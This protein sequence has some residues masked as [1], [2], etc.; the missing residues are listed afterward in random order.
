MSLLAFACDPPS[1]DTVVIEPSAQS[2][3]GLR[4]DTPAPIC[5]ILHGLAGR[6][7]GVE[8]E[9]T[10]TRGPAAAWIVSAPSLESDYRCTAAPGE[11]RDLTHRSADSLRG[12]GAPRDGAEVACL[13]ALDPLLEDL[14]ARLA[15]LPMSGRGTLVLSLHAPDD[16]AA[17]T[18]AA[19]SLAESLARFVHTEQVYVASDEPRLLVE[20]RD[21]LHERQVYNVRTALRIEDRAGTLGT[22]ALDEAYAHEIDVVLV[23]ARSVDDLVE[24][25]SRIALAEGGVAF[26]VHRADAPSDLSNLV[27]RRGLDL[28]I[29]ALAPALAEA[30]SLP[31]VDDFDCRA[32]L[33]TRQRLTRYVAPGA[34]S[35]PVL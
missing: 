31:P 6:Q 8:L 28:A 23:P 30:W 29:G 22:A 35:C 14:D 19:L 3:A 15:A 2:L 16:H 10:R 9:L 18:E 13:S 24:D 17:R 32:F 21:A 7:R 33:Q 11:A 26:G 1:N 27:R 20:V 25:A 5:R 12:C 4:A 34:A